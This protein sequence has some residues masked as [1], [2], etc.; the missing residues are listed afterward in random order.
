MLKFSRLEPEK[1]YR[2]KD[3]FTLPIQG[4]KIVGKDNLITI[5]CN[6]MTETTNFFFK[7]Y[8]RFRGYK[9]Y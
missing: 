2:V 4:E 9:K 3:K 1:L 5:L 6:S 7:P 8:I